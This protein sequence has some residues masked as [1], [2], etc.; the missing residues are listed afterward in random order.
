MIC[1]KPFC[2]ECG[3]RRHGV[4][5]C[6]DHGDI[7]VIEGLAGVFGGEDELHVRYLE[8]VLKETGYHPHLYIR[9][10]HPI[11]T[12]FHMAGNL[13]EAQG[14]I[15]NA[16]LILVPFHEFMEVQKVLE[17]LRVDHD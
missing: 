3:K 12:A 4:Y 16:I 6:N 10:V 11:S 14:R 7:P 17:A 1:S 9:K 13:F 15:S 5:L 8:S 2:P